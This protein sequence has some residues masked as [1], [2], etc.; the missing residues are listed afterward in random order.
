MGLQEFID[1]EMDA[2]RNNVIRVRKECPDT[3]CM[4]H[5]PACRFLSIQWHAYV[6]MRVMLNAS[7]LSGVIIFTLANV[8]GMNVGNAPAR[9]A[10]MHGF[11]GSSF[12]GPPLFDTVRFRRSL[13]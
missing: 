12:D 3:A 8:M 13:L 2:Y 4:R 10:G 11:S 7:A 9:L 6:Q 5:S 1:L